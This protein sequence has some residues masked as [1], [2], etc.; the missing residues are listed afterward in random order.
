MP[1][2]EFSPTNVLQRSGTRWGEAAF[3][4]AFS[5]EPFERPFSDL[6]NN[7]RCNPSP[8]YAE[9]IHAGDSVYVQ[10]RFPFQPGDT[11]TIDFLDLAGNVLPSDFA[12]L[13]GVWAAYLANNRFRQ[14]LWLPG[15]FAPDFFALRITHEGR[16]YLTDFYTRNDLCDCP[17]PT[18]L[19]EG[20]TNG[21]TCL[22]NWAGDYTQIG[23]TAIEPFPYIP[24]VRHYGELQWRGVPIETQESGVGALSS[25]SYRQYEAMLEP[26]P[27]YIA[28][29]I[30]ETLGGRAVWVDG[31]L[32]LMPDGGL[33]LDTVHKDFF[34]FSVNLRDAANCTSGGACL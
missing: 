31:N 24:R 14:N 20:D 27:G 25:T 10:T 5:C 28:E 3:G 17:S 21:M 32:E 4:P 11:L 29:R 18:V 1:T 15:E 8:C 19:F 13:G 26:A 7:R 23:G 12:T 33:E 16:E 34:R 6:Y 2:Y 22:G 30:R 9:P